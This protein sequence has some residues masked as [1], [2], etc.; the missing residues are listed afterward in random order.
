[1]IGRWPWPTFNLADSMLVVGAGLITIHVIWFDGG[2]KTF[3]RWKRFR[4][5]RAGDSR[6]GRQAEEPY[7]GGTIEL[8]DVEKVY[9]LDQTEVAAALRR[10]AFD[11][12]GSSWP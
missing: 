3:V 8:V 9:Q 4:F 5:S 12:A 2:K 11:R 1:M 10:V 6:V 7:D